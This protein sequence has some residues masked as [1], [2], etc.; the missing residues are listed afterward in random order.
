MLE[1][2]EKYNVAVVGATGA[3]GK[4]M[5]SILAERDFPL[6]ELRPLASER[7]LGK[8]VECGRRKV[9]VEVLGDDSFAGVDIALFS[10]GAA[11]SKVYGPKAVAAGAVVVDNSSAFRMDDDIPLI[12][13]EVNRAAIPDH[14]GIIA[15]PNCSTIQMVVALKPIHD[16]ARIKRIVVA[17]YQAVS[18]AGGRA[19]EELLEQVKA[20]GDFRF[21]SPQVFPHQIAFNLIPHI[22]AFLA[23]GYTK[24]EMKM[25]NETHKIMGDASIRVSA[26]CVRVPVFR[27]HSE[28]VN[29][30]TERKITVEQVRELLAYAEGVTVYDHPEDLIYPMPFEASGHDDVLVG[31]IR[32]DLSVDNG[33]S[34]WV[35]SDNL[36]K[37][38]AL[39]AIQIA[40]E[41]IPGGRAHGNA[42]AEQARG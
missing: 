38:A 21:P 31:R 1:K 28:V 14:P 22:D 25:V 29:V 36:R 23:N 13:P 27:A 18:G 17:T 2:K 19:M 9:K 11:R 5:L 4:E 16:V 15:N 3:V 42:A 41:L 39:N 40:E 8:E 37:G 35:V 20:V 32:E 12:V 6:G 7:S 24:E 26:T 30:E 33:I 34:M 10:A